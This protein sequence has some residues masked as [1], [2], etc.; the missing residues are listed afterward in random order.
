MVPLKAVGNM[1]FGEEKKGKE[2]KDIE[3][4][5]IRMRVVSVI[6]ILT[7]HGLKKCSCNLELIK[8]RAATVQTFVAIAGK[9]YYTSNLINYTSWYIAFLD[10][11]VFSRVVNLF[12][13]F[14]G[15]R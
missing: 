2:R 8:K 13:E 10:I 14:Y 1:C 9:F 12:S 3:N 11:V 4:S 15:I 7:R 6:R 5:V